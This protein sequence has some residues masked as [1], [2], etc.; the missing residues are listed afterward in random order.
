[1][2]IPRQAAGTH[3]TGM[4]SCLELIIL[5]HSCVVFCRLMHMLILL[6]VNRQ[7][8]VLN[9][10]NLAELYSAVQQHQPKQ[11]PLSSQPGM[12]SISVK[13]SMVRTIVN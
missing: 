3:P 9:R 7:A 1:M 10:S 8:F 12:D 2:G 4:H 6:S 13:S 5:Q 11:G